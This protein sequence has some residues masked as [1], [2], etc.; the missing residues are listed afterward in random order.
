M[1][2]ASPGDRS[3]L[4]AEHD[5]LAARLEARPSVDVARNGFVALFAGLVA[6]G[7]AW[8][9]L[10]DRYDKL[11]PS[12][13]GLA[14]PVLFTTASAVAGALGAALLLGGA[15]TL[16]RSRRMARAEAALFARLLELRRLLEIDA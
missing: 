11:D 5:D 8:A 12:D 2:D 4:R 9:L 3:S 7:I 6:A 13:L 16:R 10:W 15:L 1:A 14:H